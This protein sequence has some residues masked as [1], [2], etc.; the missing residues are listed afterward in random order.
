M[1]NANLRQR[2]FL[3][4]R[5]HTMIGSILEKVAE[6]IAADVLDVIRKDSGYQNLISRLAS[7][8]TSVATGAVTAPGGSPMTPV[9]RPAP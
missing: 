4:E 8:A 5:G 3:T 9:A 1:I 2:Y 7:Q 6:H